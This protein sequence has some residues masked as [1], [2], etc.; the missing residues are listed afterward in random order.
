MSS[1]L[2]KCESASSGANKNTTYIAY[3]YSVARGENHP[4]RSID[5]A[6]NIHLM[7]AQ[8]ELRPPVRRSLHVNG[9]ASLPASRSKAEISGLTA[10]TQKSDSVDKSPPWVSTPGRK[11]APNRAAFAF[12]K[13]D[14]ILEGHHA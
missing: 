1:T 8:R 11:A 4:V 10:T 5:Q 12:S 14:T 3:A 6:G 13:P 7:P 2:L 9:R